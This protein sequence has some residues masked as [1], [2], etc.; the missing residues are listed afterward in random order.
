MAEAEQRE[1]RVQEE[2][3]QEKEAMRRTYDKQVGQGSSQ[4]EGGLQ[5]SMLPCGLKPLRAPITGVGC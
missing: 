3:R 1:K 2:W 5:R 4:G